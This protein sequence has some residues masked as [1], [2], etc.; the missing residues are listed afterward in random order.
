[1]GLLFQVRVLAE[2][3]ILFNGL[4]AGD[5]TREYKLVGTGSHFRLPSSTLTNP[6]FAYP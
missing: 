5:E 4:Q 1:M 6:L 2:E 3:P